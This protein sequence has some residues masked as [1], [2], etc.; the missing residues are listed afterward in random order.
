MTEDE[1]L[2][3]E[4]TVALRYV[5]DWAEDVAGDT[6]DAEDRDFELNTITNAKAVLSKS[7][8]RLNKESN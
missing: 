5:L 6:A 7:D 3:D 1:K 8:T 2:I 4:L